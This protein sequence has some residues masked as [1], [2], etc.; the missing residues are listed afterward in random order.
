MEGRA[1]ARSV[2]SV[3][4]S[5]AASLPAC[6]PATGTTRPLLPLLCAGANYCS[7]GCLC[8]SRR[9]EEGENY[10]DRKIILYRYCNKQKNGHK[11][12]EKERKKSAARRFSL[13]RFCF[14]HP[15]VGIKSPFLLLASEIFFLYRVS[16]FSACV[17]QAKIL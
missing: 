4:C 1:W 15:L 7:L 10:I 5:V 11:Q 17:L 6:L 8:G 12:R 14:L 3:Q 2:T 13:L 16:F 9:E